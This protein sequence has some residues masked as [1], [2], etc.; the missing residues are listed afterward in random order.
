MLMSEIHIHSETPS[1]PPHCTQSPCLKSLPLAHTEPSLGQG[2][3]HALSCTQLLTEVWLQSLGRGSENKLS[4]GRELP[5]GIV[6]HSFL[7]YSSWNPKAEENRCMLRYMYDIE[8]LPF[9]RG[10]NKP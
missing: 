6:F 10:K 4:L 8:L 2:S 1:A 3:G 7:L 5:K 9:S